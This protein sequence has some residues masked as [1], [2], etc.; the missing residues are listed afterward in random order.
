MNYPKTNGIWAEVGQL[1]AKNKRKR[2]NGKSG[3]EKQGRAGDR[4][5]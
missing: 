3:V 4:G 1:N 5:G 2:N